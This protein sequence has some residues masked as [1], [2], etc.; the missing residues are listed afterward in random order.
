[1]HWKGVRMR[2]FLTDKRRDAR[3]RGR[4]GNKRDDS[5]RGTTRIEHSCAWR[6][7]LENARRDLGLTWCE[8]TTL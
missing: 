2:C 5:H 6:L 1:M 7:L 4:L 8:V 3:N